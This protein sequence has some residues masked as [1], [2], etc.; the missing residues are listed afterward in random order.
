MPPLYKLNAPQLATLRWIAEGSPE[1]VMEGYAHRISA[2]ALKS[3]GL[4]RISGRGPAWQAQIT[5]VGQAH[6]NGPA[7]AID[8]VE[9]RNNK[10]SVPSGTS[11]AASRVEEPELREDPAPPQN[12]ASRRPEIVV[13]PTLRGAHEF[14]IATRKAAVGLRADDDGRIR[15]GPQAGVVHVVLSRPLLRRALLV[16][17]GLLREAIKRGWQ[18]VS[19]AGTGYGDRPG[20]GIEI[21]VH[22]YPVEVHEL[23]ETVPFTSA[24][25][26]AWRSEWTWRPEGRAGQMPPPQLKR[27]QATGRLRLLLPNGYGGG[28]ATW[29]EG[30]RGPL[31]SKLPSVLRT[32]EQ[33]ARADDEAAVKRALIAEER[34]RELEAREAQARRARIETARVERLLTEVAAWRRSVDVRAYIDALEAMLPSVDPRERAR[35]ANWC[36]WARGW[37]DRSDPTR[38]TSLISGL[39]EEHDQPFDRR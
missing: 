28:R 23:T 24:E 3:R 17:Q 11:L 29:G 7:S 30:P 32:L 21:G 25:V 13:P 5:P 34:Q 35:V 12:P 27:K 1:G 33:R 19:Y 36:G 8:Q 2:A 26:A 14:V 15:V 37:A 22:R 20:V 38:R 6:L 39:N 4:V 9:P 10:G 18:V 31:E 16:V